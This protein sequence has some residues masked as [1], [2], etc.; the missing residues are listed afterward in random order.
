MTGD[1]V[2]ATDNGDGSFTVTLPG[3]HIHRAVVFDD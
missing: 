2:T 1:A 3:L